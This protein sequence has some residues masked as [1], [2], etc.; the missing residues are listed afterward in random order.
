MLVTAA[1]G[2]AGSDDDTYAGTRE[3]GDEL[4]SGKDLGADGNGELRVGAAR[5]VRQAPAAASSALG[6]HFLV[7]TDSREVAAPQVGHEHDVAPVSSVAAIGPAAR[8]VLLPSEMDRAVAP[9]AGYDRQLGAIV[10]HRRERYLA[11]RRARQARARLTVAGRQQAARRRS[12][13]A[14][15]RATREESPRRRRR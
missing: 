13:L 6:A 7:R 11:R 1:A 10:K 9:A 5:A 3:V 4:V 2:P 14:R 12:R 15:E 8:H